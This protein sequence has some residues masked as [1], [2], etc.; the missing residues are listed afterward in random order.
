[1][2]VLHCSTVPFFFCLCYNKAKLRTDR[3]S[4]PEKA[5]GRKVVQKFEFACSLQKY[6][7]F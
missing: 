5:R 3:A 7:G 1:M 4:F 2:A 6:T